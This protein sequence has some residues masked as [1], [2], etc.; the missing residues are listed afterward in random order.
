MVWQG[1]VFLAYSYLNSPDQSSRFVI[2]CMCWDTPSEKTGFRQLP[3]VSSVFKRLISCYINLL[4]ILSASRGE[5]LRS[6]L[7]MNVCKRFCFVAMYWSFFLSLSYLT[8][9][10]YAGKRYFFPSLMCAAVIFSYALFEKIK[11]NKSFTRFY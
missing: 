5:L 8:F 3:I 6:V 4:V 2:L 9:Y 1:C 10:I 11:Y 7:I